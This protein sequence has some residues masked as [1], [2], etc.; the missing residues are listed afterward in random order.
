MRTIECSYDL[1]PILMLLSL[2]HGMAIKRSL[3]ELSDNHNLNA[4]RTFP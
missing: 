4:M 3:S 1:A 2:G